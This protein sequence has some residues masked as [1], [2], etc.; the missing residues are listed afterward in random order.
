[1]FRFFTT[2]KWAL[3]AWLGTALSILSSLWIQVE[4]DVNDQLMV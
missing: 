3:W 4:I 2:R 1:M